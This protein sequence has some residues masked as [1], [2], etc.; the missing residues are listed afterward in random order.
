MH[1]TF[2]NTLAVVIAGAIAALAWAIS[3]KAQ[4]QPSGGVEAPRKPARVIP[5]DRAHNLDFLFEALKAA[6]DE[7]SAKA[8]EERIAAIWL[9]SKSDTANLLMTRASAAIEARDFDLALELLNAIVV[10]APNYVEAWN[11]RATIYYMKND[12]GRAVADI[13]RVLSLEP[14]HFGAMAGLGRIFQSIGDDRHALEIYRRAL[15]INPHLQRIP[16]IV[17]TLTEKV[18]GRDI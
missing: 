5:R 12:F 6:P 16:D 9:A 17:K 4:A 1:R 8:V 7:A 13:R 18:E 3:D 11:R 2:R 15:A 10:V 14:R